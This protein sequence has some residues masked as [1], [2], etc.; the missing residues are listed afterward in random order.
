MTAC[1]AVTAADAV[2]GAAYPTIHI[3]HAGWPRA[4]RT[5][6]Q[7]CPVPPPQ[8]P[9]YAAYAAHNYHFI[10]WAASVAGDLP[11]ARAAAQRLARDMSAC[12]LRD[13]APNI[14]T[15]LDAYGG[16]IWHVYIRFGLWDECIAQPID[17][18][19]DSICIATACMQAYARGVAFAAKGNVA[20]ARAEL[21]RLRRLMAAPQLALR[22][23]HNNFVW[24]GDGTGT[25]LAVALPYL[26]GEIAWREGHADRALSLLRTAA[27]AEAALAYDEP[28]GWLVPVRHAI[29]CLSAEAGR[30]RDAAEA[31]L[32]DLSTLP[33]NVWALRQL[34]TI[35][36]RLTADDRAALRAKSEVGSGQAA[37]LADT[38]VK[39]APWAALTP[40]DRQTLCTALAAV[41]QPIVP[42]A[43]PSANDVALR[44][45][46]AERGVRGMTVSASCACGVAAGAAPPAS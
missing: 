23:L 19:V 4:P 21:A 39:E 24:R 8:R 41:N 30:Y 36:P 29:G 3:G 38:L 6:L 45:A 26:E 25:M 43:L 9:I 16:S 37:A 31:L 10:A 14:A 27:A 2:A 11:A 15:N 35:L 20:A 17:D 5:L 12:C 34:E 28:P 13:I 1:A 44:L 22:R 40:S 32:E 18:D 7:A 46:L 42:T 33:D